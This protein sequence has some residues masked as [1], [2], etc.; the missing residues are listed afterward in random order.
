MTSSQEGSQSDAE[1]AQLDIPAM[2]RDGL[3]DLGGAA[4]RALFGAGAVGAAIALDRLHVIP[5]SLTYLAEV[6]RAG[7][8]RYGARLAEP[9]PERAQI[10]AIQ[11]WLA[12]AAEVAT[13]VD[14]DEQVARWLEAVATII[15]V[16]ISHRGDQLPPRI[17]GEPG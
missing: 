6:V 14:H 10:E 9:L 2:L 17:E 5:R 12:Q 1:L 8:T 3:A 16:R 11:P 15:A 4:H 7:G 13:T